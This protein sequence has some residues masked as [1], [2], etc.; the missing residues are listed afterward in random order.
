MCSKLEAHLLELENQQEDP[1]GR[2]TAEVAARTKALA[3]LAFA[4]VRK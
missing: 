4:A 1:S 2:W 3:Y